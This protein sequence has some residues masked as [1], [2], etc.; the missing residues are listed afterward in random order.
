M[1]PSE[2]V[3]KRQPIE[4]AALFDVAAAARQQVNAALAE[5][6][7]ATVKR[8]QVDVL[9]ASHTQLYALADALTSYLE[10]RVELAEQVQASIEAVQV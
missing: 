3:L 5:V 2:A 7:N 10:A 8:Q 1:K 9:K 6:Y 4:K